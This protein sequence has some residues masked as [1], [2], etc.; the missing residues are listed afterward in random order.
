LVAKKSAGL[1]MFRRRSATVELLLVH[2]GGP[3]WAKKDVGS[4]SIPKGEYEEPD[5]P[6]ETAKREFREETGF[7]VRE[8]FLALGAL[9]QPSGKLITAWAFEGDCDP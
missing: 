5:D 8:P 1:L 4:W 6:L 3:F 7:Q 2:P 9:K